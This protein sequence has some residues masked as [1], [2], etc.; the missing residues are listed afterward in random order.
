L[1]EQTIK[2]KDGSGGNEKK[3]TISAVE[4]IANEV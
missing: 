1:P 2:M 3:A 4:I